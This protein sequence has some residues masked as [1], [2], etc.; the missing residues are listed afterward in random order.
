MTTDL[1]ASEEGREMAVQTF[2]ISAENARMAGRVIFVDGG[3]DAESR[4]DNIW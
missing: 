4:S 3:F 2:L 1:F